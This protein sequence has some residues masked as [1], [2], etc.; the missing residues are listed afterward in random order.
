MALLAGAEAISTM[1]DLLARGEKPD[2]SETVGG[3]I[4]DRGYAVDGLAG[5]VLVRH[6][7]M[8]LLPATTPCSRTPAASG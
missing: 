7:A 2:W 4:E 6:G 3:S 5:E 1:R 8:R